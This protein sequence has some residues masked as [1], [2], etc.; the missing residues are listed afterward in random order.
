LLRLNFEAIYLSK[1]EKNEIDKIYK[2]KMPEVYKLYS[3]MI[4][5]I[6]KFDMETVEC[7]ALALRDIFRLLQKDR[8]YSQYS[9]LLKNQGYF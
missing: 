9:L 6:K 8:D 7:V 2:K 4:Q 1:E 5:I 3:R